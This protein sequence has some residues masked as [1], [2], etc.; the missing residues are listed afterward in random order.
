MFFVFIK[1]YYK[2]GVIH[3]KN[4][5][6]EIIKEVFFDTLPILLGVIPFGFTCGIM[7]VSSGF[8]A[9]EIILMSMLV[10]AGASQFVAISMI[11]S[12][13]TNIAVIGLTT[14]LVNLRHLIL[15][16]SLAPYILKQKNYLQAL[17]AFG[18][19]DESYV[20]TVNRI[21]K[22]GYNYHYHLGLHTILYIVWTLSTAL[23]AVLANHISNPLK[24][25][26]D[27]IIPATFLVLLI[28]R[29]INKA[30]L[31]VCLVSGITSIIGS[32]FLPGKWYIIIACLMGSITGFVCERRSVNAK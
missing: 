12:G 20:L 21:E 27:F 25:E 24:W 2:T 4:I 7:G 8:S 19:T 31:L 3:I 29:L 17:I 23:G 1:I 9:F 28:P 26:I 18:L 15:G 30:S 5:K 22:N 32:L 6:I 11:G 14:L 10:F 13:V 16:A